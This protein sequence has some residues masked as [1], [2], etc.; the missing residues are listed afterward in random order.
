VASLCLN[1]CLH[2]D[3]RTMRRRAFLSLALV[4]AWLGMPSV[5]LPGANAFVISANPGVALVRLGGP[6]LASTRQPLLRRRLGNHL[7]VGASRVLGYNRHTLRMCD[8]APGHVSEKEEPKAVEDE[9]ILEPSARAARASEL[10]AQATTLDTE[11]G[12]H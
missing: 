6:T 5:G 10:R 8:E 7:R 4:A 3:T 2:T 12:G 11:A 1:N 9:E